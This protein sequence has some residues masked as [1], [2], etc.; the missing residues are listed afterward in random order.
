[1]PAIV[2][3]H[4]GV[5]SNFGFSASAQKR[6]DSHITC[7]VGFCALCKEEVYF[8][9]RG[10]NTEQVLLHWPRKREKAAEELSSQCAKSL[11]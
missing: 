1:M 4:C 5:G 9:V 2:C 6:T 3:P 11:R 10:D 7:A 8:E